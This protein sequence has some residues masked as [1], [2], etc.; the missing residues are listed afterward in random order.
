MTTSVLLKV[1]QM[2]L[3]LS[4]SLPMNVNPT[5]IVNFAGML[6]SSC[7]TH[8]RCYQQYQQC[9]NYSNVM[10]PND[11]SVHSIDSKHHFTNILRV[12]WVK[13]Q[14]HHTVCSGKAEVWSL[15]YHS[16]ITCCRIDPQLLILKQDMCLGKY[17][18]PQLRK[19]TNPERSRHRQQLKY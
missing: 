13:D 10:H 6:C 4:S 9:N 11:R 8:L 2:I 15:H 5:H 3:D 18:D 7:G 1:W 16:S 12:P 17:L 14:Q 19:F